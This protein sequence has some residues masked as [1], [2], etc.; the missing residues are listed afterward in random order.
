MTSD[1]DNAPG[2]AVR[3]SRGRNVAEPAPAAPAAAG[4]GSR[5][6]AAAGGGNRKTAPA[7]MNARA[8]RERAARMRAVV[9]GVVEAGGFVRVVVVVVV[10]VV[11]GRLPSWWW[12]WS[13]RRPRGRGTRSPRRR[14]RDR[15]GDPGCAATAGRSARCRTRRGPAW[16]NT[17]GETPSPTLGQIPKFGSLRCDNFATRASTRHRKMT[18]DARGTRRRSADRPG[19]DPVR[20]RGHDHGVPAAAAAG[21]ARLPAGR[22]RRR[23]APPGPARSPTR[24]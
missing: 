20:R 14:G 17:V 4:S 3:A 18:A 9:L 15:P 8:V 5:S 7:R 24:G 10:V 1:G 11:A 13:C 22:R 21:R 2:A 16:R 19:A 6:S 23:A 12:S